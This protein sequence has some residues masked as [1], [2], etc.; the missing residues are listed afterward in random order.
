MLTGDI[1]HPYRVTLPKLSSQTGTVITQ[2]VS[3]GPWDPVSPRY[4]F[5]Q[6]S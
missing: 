3:R 6:F 1:F 4:P 5:P 2:A